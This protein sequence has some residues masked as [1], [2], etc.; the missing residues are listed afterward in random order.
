MCSCGRKNSNE[1]FHSTNSFINFVFKLILRIKSFGGIINFQC[2]LKRSHVIKRYSLSQECLNF[3][4]QYVKQM[5]NTVRRIQLNCSF[6]IFNR[7]HKLL[8]FYIASSSVCINDSCSGATRRCN[9]FRIMLDRF[10]IFLLLIQSVSFFLLFV[11]IFTP[12]LH[13]QLLPLLRI[14][15]SLVNPFSLLYLSTI[16]LTVKEG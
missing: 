15:C 7:Q 6:T 1:S 11:W 16:L 4:N 3:G 12:H 5:I 2:I 14:T 9:R 8:Q 10:C 13:S